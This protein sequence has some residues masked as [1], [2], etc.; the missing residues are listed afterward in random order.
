[1]KYTVDDYIHSWYVGRR[2]AH[3][4]TLKKDLPR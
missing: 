4:E 3:L 1:M 2:A